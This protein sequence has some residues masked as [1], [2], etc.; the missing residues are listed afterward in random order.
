MDRKRKRVMKGWL[1]I[2][3][4]NP[5]GKRWDWK[6]PRRA[7]SYKRYSKMPKVAIPNGLQS[8]KTFAHLVH[9]FSNQ[10]LLAA[11]D[12]EL[13]FLRWSYVPCSFEFH[14]L[15]VE[16]SGLP[17]TF[18]TIYCDQDGHYEWYIDSV[19]GAIYTRQ[20]V[21]VSDSLPEFLV[22]LGIQNEIVY[23]FS[24]GTSRSFE[25]LSIPARKY[26]QDLY[27]LSGGQ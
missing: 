4:V 11:L 24:S 25:R 3:L 22:R 8:V 19:D 27:G 6:V 16:K 20:Q 2:S 10:S 13:P 18:Q 7:L 26:L 9:V 21:R 14:Q 23:T 1:G 5:T 15:N 12:K 17:R